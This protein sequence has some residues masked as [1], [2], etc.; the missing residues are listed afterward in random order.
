MN[1]SKETIEANGF[2]VEEIEEMRQ[3][4]VEH[5]VAG[6]KATKTKKMLDRD[7]GLEPAAGL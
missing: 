6:L 5:G 7:K 2:T 4:Y 1:P 3:R